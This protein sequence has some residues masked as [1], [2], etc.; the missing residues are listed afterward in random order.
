MFTAPELQRL[1]MI[2]TGTV[3]RLWGLDLPQEEQQGGD[4]LRRL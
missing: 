1:S 3:I 2:F 4:A